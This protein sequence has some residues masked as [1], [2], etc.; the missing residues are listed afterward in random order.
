[1]WLVRELR[2]PMLFFVPRGSLA[3]REAN[4]KLLFFRRTAGRSG[5]E[6]SESV[7][8]V[9]DLVGD[10]EMVSCTSSLASAAASAAGTVCCSAAPGAASRCQSI[11]RSSGCVGS[12]SCTS[13]A[14]PKSLGIG[15]GSLVEALERRSERRGKSLVSSLA[16]SK[17]AGLLL[18]VS[19]ADIKVSCVLRTSLV[20]CKRASCG[21]LTGDRRGDFCGIGLG[22]DSC[23]AEDLTGISGSSSVM[24]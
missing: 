21:G 10:A 24:S 12:F 19:A 13:G 18:G 1:M 3:G 7:S 5:L 14:D 8:W 11:P 22:G 17:E 6:V 2:A 4:V 9:S 23:R 20:S 15:A 16:V